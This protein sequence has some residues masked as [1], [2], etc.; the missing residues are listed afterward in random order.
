MQAYNQSYFTSA[1]MMYPITSFFILF[2]VIP[3]ELLPLIGIYRKAYQKSI[4]I[5]KIKGNFAS[6]DELWKNK[7]S[8]LKLLLIEEEDNII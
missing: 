5:E 1:L 6:W 8:D 3:D 2:V 4:L 7:S